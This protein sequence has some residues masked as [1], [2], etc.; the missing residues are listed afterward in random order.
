MEAEQQTL[1]GVDIVS[2]KPETYFVTDPILEPL[3]Y[4]QKAGDAA[5]RKEY[6]EFMALWPERL[7]SQEFS[8]STLLSPPQK[9]WIAKNHKKDM[10]INAA[11]NHWSLVGTAIH[12]ALENYPHGVKERRYG[13]LIKDLDV[14]V[15]HKSDLI[16]PDEGIYIDYKNVSCSSL[17]YPKD[18]WEAQ[19]NFG[20][21]LA[22]GNG[23]FNHE[24][25]LS[26]SKEIKISR[27]CVVANLIDWRPHDGKALQ[28]SLEGS[29]IINIP[30]WEPGRVIEWFRDRAKAHLYAREHGPLPCTDE[31]R[32]QR[33]FYKVYGYTKAGPLS[34][35][36]ATGETFETEEQ[37]Q[38]WADE[39]DKKVEIKKIQGRALNCEFYCQSA[40]WC[41]QYQSTIQ[42]VI[43]KSRSQNVEIKP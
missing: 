26:K 39:N 14:L 22:Q 6:D 19:L 20:A 5:Y 18:D 21:W 11:N 25:K 24:G 35:N 36:A 28:V 40:P 13:Y 33:D 31:E 34:K 3:I 23:W 43:H 27:I 30:I 10:R 42:P 4:A 15:H 29:K 8:L 1:L 41:S 16:L 2:S 17:K 7:R 38:Q 32:W 37:A 9:A 12:S